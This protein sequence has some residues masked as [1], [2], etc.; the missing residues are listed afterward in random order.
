M[1]TTRLA[2]GLRQDRLPGLHSCGAHYEIVMTSSPARNLTYH[3]A[4][5]NGSGDRMVRTIQARVGLPRVWRI[6][7]DKDVTRSLWIVMTPL[8]NAAVEKE[9][10]AAGRISH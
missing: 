2:F 3:A 5:T 7:L 10:E 9:T 4:R 6:Q 1:P 8:G